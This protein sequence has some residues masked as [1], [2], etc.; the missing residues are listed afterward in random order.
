MFAIKISSEDNDLF[1]MQVPRSSSANTM[2]ILGIALVL[3]IM[4]AFILFYRNSGQ[5]IYLKPKENNKSQEDEKAPNTSTDS[6][7]SDSS[8]ISNSQSMMNQGVTKAPLF[9]ILILVIQQL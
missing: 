1:G 2:L 9:Q 3:L 6:S 7:N 8:T 5:P 4:L